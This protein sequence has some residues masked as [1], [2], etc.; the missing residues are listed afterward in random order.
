MD[1][2]LL[3]I[4][5]VYQFCGFA[6]FPLPLDFSMTIPK[7]SQYKWYIYNGVIITLF[8][9]LVLHNII[10]YEI[11]LEGSDTK[12]LTYLSF[13]AICSVRFLAVIIAI[14]S[15]INSKQQVEFIS[16]LC[17]IDDIFTKELDMKPNYKRMRYVA[18]FWLAVWLTKSVILTSLVMYG[19]I[20]DDISTWNKCFWF[21]LTMPVILSAIRYYHITEYIAA[22]GY[23]FE[24][25]NE[26]LNDI[27][28]GTKRLNTN[29]KLRNKE[30]STLNHGQNTS[31]ADDRIYDEIVCLR[32]IYHILWECTGL[33]N[34]P[35]RWS[36]LTLIATSFYLIVV[37]YYRTLVWLL[38][39]PDEDR[40]SNIVIFF[41]W[42]SGHVFYFIKLSSTCNNVLQQ[43]R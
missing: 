15:V 31:S 19:V 17:K 39:D 6:P 34:K 16:K 18:I 7:R 9:A 43:V 32:Q 42:C 21:L 36:L 37:N 5:R 33:L 11:F 35:F 20:L 22:L 24:M 41:I 10:S 27:Y 1:R 38:I 30:K 28:E 25:I 13:I 23:R 29:D 3:A 4:F 2:E 12:L 26:R 40:T 14:E 8:G